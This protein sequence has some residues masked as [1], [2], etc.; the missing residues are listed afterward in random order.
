M[1]GP[2]SAHH[3]SSLI[4][5]ISNRSQSCDK[6]CLGLAKGAYLIHT[7]C[8]SCSTKISLSEP[9]RAENRKSGFERSGLPPLRAVA[10]A[11]SLCCAHTPPRAVTPPPTHQPQLST[12]NESSI[13][14]SVKIRPTMFHDIR[15]SLRSKK[16]RQRNHRRFV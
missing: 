15:P 2:T 1:R 4:R 12:I 13:T 8:C 14:R 6:N 16:H 9:R 11:G 5:A 10:A 3:G 7:M